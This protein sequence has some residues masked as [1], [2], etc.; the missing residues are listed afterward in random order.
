ML[1]GKELRREE[2]P[3][4]PLGTDGSADLCL[5]QSGQVSRQ[6]GPGWG[7]VTDSWGKEPQTSLPVSSPTIDPRTPGSRLLFL[8]PG[9]SLQSHAR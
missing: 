9:K 7:F 3:D 1:P 4:R 6:V 8:R 2:G 5:G